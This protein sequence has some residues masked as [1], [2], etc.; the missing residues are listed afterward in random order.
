[1]RIVCDRKKLETATNNCM[2]AVSIRSPLPILSHLMFEVKEGKMC[3]SSTDLEMG[4]ESYIDVQAEP[5]A[6]GD[7]ESS[8]T[9]PAKIFSDIIGQLPDGEVIIEV[10][11]GQIKITSHRSEFSLVTLPSEEFPIFPRPEGGASFK[12]DIGTFKDMLRLVLFACASSEESRAILS[13]VMLSISENKLTMVSTDGRRLARI[14]RTIDQLF[15]G[16]EQR[17]IPQH[18][19][20]E[21]SKL[22]KD[23]DKEMEISFGE[24]QI[25]FSLPDM[26]LFSRVLEGEYPDYTALIRKDYNTRI[27]ADRLTLLTGIRRAIITAQERVT[28]G[29]VKLTFEG[30]DLEISSNTADLGRAKEMIKVVKEG[31]DVSIAFNGRYIIDVL[32]N[33]EA[34]QVTLDIKDSH[35]SGII[36]PVGDDSYVYILMP[37]R[38]KEEVYT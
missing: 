30:E 29:L 11:R 19:L 7:E 14:N 20:N 12:V 6:K 36:S 18:S 10:E 5:K 15:P 23:D 1:M 22:L 31:D 27:I 34:E 16:T 28:P 33:L 9:S 3:I 38:I 26:F 8:F 13:G 37:I 25:F 17:V 2:R 21:I 32:S 35:S 24:G 4:I